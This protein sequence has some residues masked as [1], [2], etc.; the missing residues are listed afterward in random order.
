M[1]LSLVIPAFNERKR[2]P[3]TLNSLFSYFESHPPG[4]FEILVVDDGSRDGTAEAVEELGKSHLQ[5]RLLRLGSNMGRGVAVR[6]G[7]RAASG[8]LVLETDAD[9][10]VREEAIMRFVEFFDAHPDVDVLIGS[11]NAAGAE[12]LTAQPFLRV[13]LGYVFLALANLFF[14]WDIADYTL[15][16]K[17][18][19]RRA[20]EDIFR[21]Q[22]DSA[23]LAEAEI[24]FVARRRGWALRE[25]PVMWT[26]YRDSRVRPGR[27]S[28]RSAVGLAKMLWRARRG[29][30]DG[31]RRR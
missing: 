18:F 25:L 30:Y 19:R 9:G 24:V 10:S 8:E 29:D 2:L 4:N 20:A 12:I 28:W 22:F 27:D 3:R 17:M 5:L 13:F 11:R 6:E 26:D 7:I 16:F 31:G 14:G 23:Y 1:R 21:H 15:G